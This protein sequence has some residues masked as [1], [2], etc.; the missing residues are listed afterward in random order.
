MEKKIRKDTAKKEV[1]KMEKESTQ[2]TQTNFIDK[3]RNVLIDKDMH[4]RIKNE[5]I[6]KELIKNLELY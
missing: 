6:S 2:T 5:A 4:I 3:I 1:E